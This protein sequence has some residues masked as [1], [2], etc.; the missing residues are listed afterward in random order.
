MKPTLTTL[1]KIATC[2]QLSLHIPYANFSAFIFSKTLAY[3]HIHIHVSICSH[4]CTHFPPMY[5]YSTH[6]HTFLHM[7]ICV[8]IHIHLIV[9]VSVCLSSPSEC[10]LC[11]YSNLIF[12]LSFFILNIIYCQIGFHTT[13]SAHSNRCPPPCPSPTFPSPPPP[14]NP[15]FVLSIKSLLWFASLLLYL[16]SPSSPPPRSS[17]KFLRIHIRVKTYGICLSLYDLFHLA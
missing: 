4:S 10:K 1:F 5:M 7:C 3:W 12:F 15:Q 16:F 8:C 9:Y 11:G 14:I 13:P 17:V 2:T 6:M